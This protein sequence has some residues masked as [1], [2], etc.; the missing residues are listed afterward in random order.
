MN[1]KGE[2]VEIDETKP[3]PDNIT[4]TWEIGDKIAC[5]NEYHIAKAVWKRLRKRIK[6]LGGR[7]KAPV[8]MVNN[9]E[10]VWTCIKRWEDRDEAEFE[11]KGKQ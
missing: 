4:H 5:W 11:E 7:K 9:L 3:L 10:K 2:V 8:Q 1:T 6:R